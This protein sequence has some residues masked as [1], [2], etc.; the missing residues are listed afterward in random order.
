MAW[1]NVFLKNKFVLY[2]MGISNKEVEKFFIK[3]NINYLV[4][5]DDLDIDNNYVIIKS[6]GIPNNTTFLKKCHMLNL[7]II[8][9]IELFYLLRTD[10]K[11]IG[12][13]GSCGK[14]TTCSVLY[15]IMKEKYKVGLC[16]NIGIPIFKFIKE[17]LDYLIVELS[18]YQL[19]YIDKFRVDYFIILNVYNHHLNHH[20]TFNNYIN[21]KMSVIKNLSLDDTLIINDELNHYLRG[22]EIKC[23]VF[24]YSLS[25][26]RDAY[27]EDTK[28]YFNDERF[29]ISNI[30]YFKYEFNKENF[31]SI[32]ILMKLLMIDNK[33]IIDKMK[34]YSGLP[35]RMEEIINFNE[36]IVI[37]D[38]KSTS[39]NSLNKAIDYCISN[40]DDYEL[41]I[42]IGGK[43][44]IEEIRSNI[45]LIRKLNSYNVY[46][47]GENKVLISKILNIK[48]YQN[49]CDVIDNVNLNIKQVILFSP[50]A[51]S[52]DEFKSYED[53]GEKFKELILKK[54][55]N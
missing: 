53:R 11:Y 33:L 3:N 44:D 49:L 10:I 36:L 22:R 23:K 7:L 46:C 5:L 28:L 47:Y 21:A 52:F 16:G 30:E 45:S 40:Y 50:A 42:I 18:S 29:D 6:P 37:N 1:N 15:N 4:V 48:Y 17:E 54:L 51:Q 20:Q 2:G 12:I 43:I 34:S 55:N 19:E 13:T 38:S 9:D 26:K 8:N 35:H 14:T 24:T 41:N 32:F 27:Y 25:L 31:L 39:F